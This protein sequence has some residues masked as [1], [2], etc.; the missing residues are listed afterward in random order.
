[1]RHQ[2]WTKS[3]DFVFKFLKLKLNLRRKFSAYWIAR[4]FFEVLPMQQN[5]VEKK[6][7]TTNIISHYGHQN[8]AKSFEFLFKSYWNLRRKLSALNI[9]KIFRFRPKIVWGK[10]PW[11]QNWFII[12]GIK[13]GQNLAISYSNLFETY[14]VSFHTI[15]LQ[16]NFSKSFPY[17]AKLCWRK[18]SNNKYNFSL[19]AS[20]LDKIFQILIK[21]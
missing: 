20:K 21:Y 15:E 8:W 13:I 14:I 12:M 19:W 16:E 3:F 7:L 6:S 11:K 9:D 17:A 10:I 2:N 1:M 5:C 4:K 18:I